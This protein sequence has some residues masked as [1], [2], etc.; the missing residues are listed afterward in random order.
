MMTK[1]NAVLIIEANERNKQEMKMMMSKKMERKP[2]RDW[3]G[4]QMKGEK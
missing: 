3:L 2:R 4:M 1:M